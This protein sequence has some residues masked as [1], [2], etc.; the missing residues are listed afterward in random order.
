MHFPT[1]LKLA[2]TPFF[3]LKKDIP[4]ITIASTIYNFHL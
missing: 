3:K 1:I 2:V 4:Y